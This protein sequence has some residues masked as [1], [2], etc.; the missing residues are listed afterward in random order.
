MNDMKLELKILLVNQI[1]KLKF[2]AQKHGYL[3][4]YDKKSAT[5]LNYEGC[6]NYKFI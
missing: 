4:V 2:K 6:F 5:I 3:I 1:R